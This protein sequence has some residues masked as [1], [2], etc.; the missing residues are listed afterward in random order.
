MK[1]VLFFFPFSLAVVC[2]G[3]IQNPLPS[4]SASKIDSAVPEPVKVQNGLEESRAKEPIKEV[5]AEGKV[6]EIKD[7]RLPLL[8]HDYNEKKIVKGFRV[9][10]FAGGSKMEAL[11]VKADFLNHT[12]DYIAE[13]IYQSPNFKVR[14]GNFRDRLEAYRFLKIYKKE[15]PSAFIVQDEVDVSKMME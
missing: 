14:V 5:V 13:I 8:L 15:F 3:Q 9:Q 4:N 10:L 7:E 11:K 2:M 6:E 12:Q 1:F